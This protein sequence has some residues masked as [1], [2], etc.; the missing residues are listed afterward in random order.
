[1]AI[2]VMWGWLPALAWVILGAIFIGA[3]H[4]LGSLVVSLR[5]RGRTIGDIAGDLLGP[6]VR[7]IFL[8]VLVMGLWIVLAIFGLV[9]AA[10]LRQYPGAVFPVLVQIP[11]ALLIGIYIHRKG[12]NILIPS[13]LALL[14]MYASVIWG[15]WGPL[16]TFNTFLAQQPI[17]VWVSALLVYAYIASVLPVW[18]LLQ[19][20]DYI[21]A[22]QLIT[23]LGILAVGL[24]VAGVFGGIPTGAEVF[25]AAGAPL[26]SER[27]PLEIVA[28]LYNPDPVGAPPLIPILFITIACGAISGFHC[29]VASGTTSKQIS[30]ERDALPIG[31]GSML[32]EGFLATLVIVACAAGLGLGVTR[33]MNVVGQ[34]T[35]AQQSY[36]FGFIEIPNR[37]DSRL[38]MAWS[39][40]VNDPSWT[41]ALVAGREATVVPGE[42]EYF[43]VVGS[44]LAPGEET[45]PIGVGSIR[46]GPDLVLFLGRGQGEE[47]E[48]IVVPPDQANRIIRHKNH[49]I[50]FDPNRGVY[51]L[52]GKLAFNKQ[53]ESWSAAGSLAA[54][55]G[56]F[57]DGAGNLIRALGIPAH[58]GVALMGVLVASFAGT[59]MDTACR[60]QRYVI[61]ELSRTFLPRA[62]EGACPSCGYDL[63]GIERAIDAGLTACPECGESAPPI[64]GSPGLQVERAL[65]S[66]WTPFKWLATTHGATIFAV[67]TAALLAAVPPPGTP[68]SLANAGRGGLILWP[69]FGAT[70]QL[71]GGLAFLVIAAWLIARRR[72]WWFITIPTI[73]MIIL[74]AWALIWQAF[75]GNESNPSWLTDRKWLLVAIAG[76]ALALEAWLVIEVTLRL[77]RGLPTQNDDYAANEKP[78][79]SDSE[80]SR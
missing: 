72:P 24:L 10:V 20:R 68:L 18:T 76:L 79:R 4:D 25:E 40:E 56:A 17:I 44:E 5:N 15:D 78:A 32:T 13:A 38:L 52:Q 1:P 3:V 26:T 21:N 57:V 69:L 33:V 77:F 34:G 7:L 35:A 43:T 50:P 9:I 11:L 60:L 36:T 64:A 47:P 61:Q 59:T 42:D 49:T 39:R 54:M 46:N 31:Y 66:S 23:S 45:G 28:P 70:N 65:A 16:H 8:G 30:N 27:V 53:Y 14:V 19:P 48:H 12:R 37:D 67:I 41:N 22:L 73:L 2:A 6:R 55:V 62:E 58:I 29:L 71:L 75:V 74:P 51:V 80:A 63:S